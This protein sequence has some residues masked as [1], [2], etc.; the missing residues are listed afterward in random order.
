MQ[1]LPKTI[2]PKVFYSRVKLI[3]GTYYIAIMDVVKLPERSLHCRKLKLDE[4]VIDVNDLN[5]DVQE[6][7]LARDVNKLPMYAQ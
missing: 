6:E 1:I 3:K 4:L 7:Y 2:R 5:R